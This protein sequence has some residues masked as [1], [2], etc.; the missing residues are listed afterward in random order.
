MCLMR[1]MKSGYTVF[2]D[3]EKLVTS[4]MGGSSL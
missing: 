3:L 2:I 1:P 4:S